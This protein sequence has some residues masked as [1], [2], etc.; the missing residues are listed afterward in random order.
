MTMTKRQR[1]LFAAARAAAECIG[2][3]LPSPYSPETAAQPEQGSKTVC[4]GCDH[5]CVLFVGKAVNGILAVKWLPDSETDRR[6][7]LAGLESMLK[8]ALPGADPGGGRRV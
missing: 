7:C 5:R 2:L 3:N 4:M 8:Q 1:V 6:P